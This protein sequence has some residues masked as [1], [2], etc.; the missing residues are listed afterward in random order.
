MVGA[1][2]VYPA[3]LGNG[4]ALAL[5]PLALRA[6]PYIGALRAPYRKPGVTDTQTLYA[7]PGG[8]LLRVRLPILS[9]STSKNIYEA[10][11][12]RVF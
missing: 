10:F 1:V 5:A 4:L 12:S 6:R 8:T 2:R 7:I 9:T 11:E 3:G